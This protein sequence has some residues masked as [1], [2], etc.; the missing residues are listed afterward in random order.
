MRIPSI[1]MNKEYSPAPKEV[2]K[3]GELGDDT[4]SRY[5]VDLTDDRERNAFI[6]KC[7]KI[8]RNSYEYKEFVEFLKSYMDMRECA[9]FL[10]VNNYD[11]RNIKIEIHH[12][13]FTLYDI[14]D[15]VL[16]KRAAQ[17][18][19]VSLLKV[20]DEVMGLHYM[21][22]VGLIPLSATV[23]SLVHSGSISIPL[24]N[25]FGNFH[26]F[27]TQYQ[28]TM[29]PELKETFQEV[30][31]NDKNVA[32]TPPD[33]LKIKYLEVE[34]SGVKEPEKLYIEKKESETDYFSKLS[35]EEK[36]QYLRE[37]LG[38]ADIEDD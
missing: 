34:M 25:V 37:K 11:S 30:L 26:V 35:P 20:C 16:R 5:T 29:N 13:P 8:V 23:H 15:S 22:Y 31:K 24:R 1:N 2:I 4:A 10:N 27:Y 9:Y 28:D 18:Q 3:V 7:E 21:G 19:S 38:I 32:L 33:I 36:H 12:A 14:V 6:K 17:N